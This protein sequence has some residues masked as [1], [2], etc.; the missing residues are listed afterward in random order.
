ML[1]RQKKQKPKNPIPLQFDAY[2]HVYNRGVNRQQTFFKRDNYHY[3]MRLYAK[4]IPSVAYLYAYCLLPNHFH[5]LLKTKSVEQQKAE[6]LATLKR[7]TNFSLPSNWDETFTP[8]KPSQQFSNFFNAYAKAINHQRNRSGSLFE[9]PFKR[10][11]VD[12]DAYFLKLIIYIHR[13]P[14][15]HKIMPDFRDWAYSSYHTLL[16]DR[17]TRLKRDDV[18]DWFNGVNDF[19]T[20][21][22]QAIDIKDIKPLLL[23]DLVD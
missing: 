5:F 9:R 17:P 7:Q 23:E 16:S 3:F 11:L 13:N 8:L 12:T 22:Q 20:I 15:W 6:A 18:L 19:Q 4:Y 2:Y 14:Q 1:M 10:I 21:H